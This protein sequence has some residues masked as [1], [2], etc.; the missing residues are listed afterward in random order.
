M[1]TLSTVGSE[2]TTPIHAM[3]IMFGAVWAPAQEIMAVGVGKRYVPVLT[4]FFIVFPPVW[5]RCVTIPC[6]SD[7]LP[8]ARNDDVV[9]L[10]EKPF[11]G[12]GI[13][14]QHYNGQ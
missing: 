2:Q 4:S 6:K 12:N 14:L 7:R 3:V 5:I 13:N 1:E 9:S 10:T 8:G 11:Y